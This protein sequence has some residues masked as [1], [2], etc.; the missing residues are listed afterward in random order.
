MAQQDRSQQWTLQPDAEGCG[1]T[2]GY[3][4]RVRSLCLGR[5]QSYPST[6]RLCS[7]PL[8]RAAWLCF[9]LLPLWGSLAGKKPVLSICHPNAHG[10]F[11]TC[12]L[13]LSKVDRFPFIPFSHHL[14]TLVLSS[15]PPSLQAKA[16]PSTHSH[17]SLCLLIVKSR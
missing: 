9:L 12:F 7:L 1:V 5:D 4:R 14:Q 10:A 15:H 6:T 11:P 3:F 13:C 8:P 2:L 16:L 17:V